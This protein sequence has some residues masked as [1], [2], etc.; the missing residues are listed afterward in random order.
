MSPRVELMSMPLRAVLSFGLA[1]LALAPAPV[2]AQQRPWPDFALTR[3]ADGQSVRSLVLVQDT[4]SLVVIVRP[5]CRPCRELVHRLATE[6]RP[7]PHRLAILLAGLSPAE[8]LAIRSAEPALPPRVWYVDGPGAALTALQV[9]GAPALFGLH[10][11]R[12][13]W[14]LRGSMFSDAQWQSVVVPWLR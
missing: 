13:A 12:I 14:T 10:G 1:V 3:V 2:T 5:G 7:A 8:A 11:D 6:L 9:S 4:P